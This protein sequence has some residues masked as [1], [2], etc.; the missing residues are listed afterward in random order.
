MPAHGQRQGQR[1][2]HHE[3]L[4][5]PHGRGCQGGQVHHDHRQSQ[6][7]QDAQ[8]SRRHVPARKGQHIA[9]VPRKR[10]LHGGPRRTIDAARSPQG[11]GQ[12]MHQLEPAQ[13]HA[14]G[15]S[16]AGQRQKPVSEAA[17]TQIMG[18]STGPCQRSQ[19][20]MPPEHGADAAQSPVAHRHRML[21]AIGHDQARGVARQQG[22]QGLVAVVVGFAQLMAGQEMPRVAQKPGVKLQR[23]I[24]A[25]N[26][27]HRPFAISPRVQADGLGFLAPAQFHTHQHPLA[28]RQPQHPSRQRNKGQQRQHHPTRQM[29]GMALPPR[30]GSLPRARSGRQDNGGEP[31]IH[32]VPSN[33]CT[34]TAVTPPHGV[35]FG[36]TDAA[37]PTRRADTPL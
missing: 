12:A 16:A 13:R 9:Q 27:H 20:Q 6:T 19:Q 29:A 4:V 22:V 26:A 8:P 17:L 31:G 28:G 5:P 3:C 21:A 2:H 33:D 30:P 37:G 24:R 10:Q 1:P 15:V 34:R 25:A 36:K 18:P 23:P 7:G 11:P 32:G 35:H 14:N